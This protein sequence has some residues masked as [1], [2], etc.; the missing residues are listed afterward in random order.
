MEAQLQSKMWKSK[1]LCVNIAGVHVI[2]HLCST[3]LAYP[4]QDIIT[5]IDGDGSFLQGSRASGGAN[6]AQ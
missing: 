4:F 3:T 2:L 1:L 5:Q 6:S